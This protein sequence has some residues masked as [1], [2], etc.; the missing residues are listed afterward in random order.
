MEFINLCPHTINVYDLD[1]VTHLLDIVKE[2][3]MPIARCE[4]SEKILPEEGGIP[5]T[6]Q[7]M[8]AVTGLPAPQ[9]GVR[10][11]VSRVVADACPDRTDLRIPGPQIR[12]ANGQPIGCR[13]LTVPKR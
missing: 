13:G 7:V 6:Q 4:Q 2:E 3:D 10:Y 1:G 12:G 8:G 5:M 9:D 11:V